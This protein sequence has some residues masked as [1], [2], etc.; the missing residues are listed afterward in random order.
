MLRN[1]NPYC[2]NVL[3]IVITENRPAPDIHSYHLCKL[4]N[5][6]RQVAIGF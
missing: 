4:T 1:E 3:S 2:P 6:Y 5:N